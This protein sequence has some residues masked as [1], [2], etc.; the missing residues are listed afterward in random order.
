[1]EEVPRTGRVSKWCGA[2]AT[3]GEARGERFH[4]CPAENTL[5]RELVVANA[6]NIFE[7]AVTETLVIENKS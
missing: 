3:D 1:M 5:G 4:T 6:S 7:G 2:V